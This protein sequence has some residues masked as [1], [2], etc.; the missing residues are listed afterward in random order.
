[1]HVLISSLNRRWP[2]WP[3]VGV[4]GLTLLAFVLR[5]HELNRWDLTFDEAVSIW[6]ARKPPL[7]M[8]RYV[9]GA[10]HEHPPFYYLSLWSWTQAAGD[11][12]FAL[13]FWSVLPGVMSV[14]LI[15]VWLRRWVGRSAGLIAALLL[16][17]SPFHIYYSQDARMYPLVGMLALLSL[18]FL[19]RILRDGRLRWWAAWGI[20]TLIGLSTHYFMGLVN[21]AETVFLIVTWRSNRRVLRPW[22]MIHLG[23][24][25]LI[26]LWFAASPGFQTTIGN[27]WTSN[28]RSEPLIRTLRV[29]SFDVIFSPVSRLGHEWLWAMLI[30]AAVG[31]ITAIGS[32]RDPARSSAGWL[33]AAVI[34]VPPALVLLTPESLASRYFIFV[35]FGYLAAVTFTITQVGRRFPVLGIAF[36]LIVVAAS[37]SRY[38]HQYPTPKSVYGDVIET[39]RS[40]RLPGDVLILNGPWQWVQLEYYQ[41]GDIP[42]IYLPPQTPPALDPVETRPALETLAHM[43]RRIWVIQ[44]AVQSADP[45]E[46]VVRWL[47]ENAFPAGT[48]QRDLRLYYTRKAPVRVQAVGVTAEDMLELR[49]AV[50]PAGATPAGDA[51]L[52]DLRW[53]VQRAPG[54]DLVASLALV[55]TDGT[56]WAEK[57]YRPGEAFA[58]P[59]TWAIGQEVA[60]RQALTIP[61]DTPPGYYGLHVNVRRADSGAALMPPT[62]EGDPWILIASV[63]IGAP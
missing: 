4:A 21:A 5:L 32:R 61:P 51:V 31:L 14:P 11:G 52:V 8:I 55:G 16:T 6:I 40:R 56:T 29:L 57:V 34:L 20:V 19:D 49:E 28:G 50:V 41:P 43:Y 58:P 35:L 7:E 22:L 46:F 60:D 38:A 27:W 47:N 24:A 18:I 37:V 3:G 54:I 53:R 12:E 33:V 45:D 30:T 59:A 25:V 13:R 9:L 26:G 36:T 2:G 10:F 39:V 23:V 62:T 15:F 48:T 17:F 44:A 1:M 63:M 42:R